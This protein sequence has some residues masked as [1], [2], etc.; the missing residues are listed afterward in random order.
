MCGMLVRTGD[1]SFGSRHSAN[2]TDCT[3]ARRWGYLFN[4]LMIA[5]M[6]VAFAPG[7]L[8]QERD[9]EDKIDSKEKELQELR[10]KIAEQRRKIRDV[11]K[12]ERGE[13]DYLKK[14][15]REE[16]LTRKLLQG[17]ADKEG[18]LEV[19]VTELREAL[20]VNE[21]IYRHRLD[22]LSKRLR[23]MYKEGQRHLWQELLDARDFGDL[24]Q[25]YKFLTMIAEQ[26]ADLVR[27]VRERQAVIENQEA[28]ITE[29]LHEVTVS[30]REKEGELDRL[31]ENE[32]KRKRTLTALKRSKSKYQK[33]IDELAQAEKKLQNFIEELEK[34]RLEQAK[35]WVSYGEKD[36][37]SLKGKLPQPVNGTTVR[38]FGRFRHPEFGT[39]T[40][41]SGIDIE[42]RSGSPIRAVARGRVEFI[43][44]LPGYGNCIILN[45][46]G[47]YYT[48]Y[49]HATRIFVEQ[50][51]R[52]ERGKVVAEIGEEGTGAGNPF[53]FEI[54]KS[55]KALDPSEWLKR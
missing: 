51:E 28:E 5:L 42:A 29:L 38:G 22:I 23:E 37:S 48:L 13:L 2:H 18:M 32:R 12:K 40:F 16:E 49:A 52:V 50:G 35:D 17:L 30:R 43:D 53:H 31:E 39:V 26:D 15:E 27:D 54:R 44:K 34:R 7:A 14:L 10:K 45:H 25:R 47:G 8:A 1:C 19:Q 4:G 9:L 55:K 21:E 6:L 33:E 3:A 36:F 11:E 46:G 41:N 20:Q 24:L